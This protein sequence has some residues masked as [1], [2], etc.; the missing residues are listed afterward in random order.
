[1]ICEHLGRPAAVVASGDAAL[2]N[3]LRFIAG[4]ERITELDDALVKAA[5]LVIFVDCSDISRLGP[6]YYRLA[7]E[8]ER[9]RPTINIDH[10]VTNARFGE[11]NIVIPEA[12][13]TAEIIAGMATELG[14]EFDVKRAT[15]LLVGIYGDTL[16]LRTPS[17]TPATMRVSA[18]L[19]GA[20]A[21]L[22]AIV[23]ALFRM[24]PYST[25]ALWA[26]A[27]QRTQWRGA[28]IWT[29]VDADMLKRAGADRTEAEGLVNF[30]AGTVGARAAA[31][32]Y[33]EPSGWRVSMRSLT[34][35]VN[36]AEMLQRFNGGGHPRAAGA[37]LAPGPDARDH[38]L[39]N[40]AAQLGPRQSAQAPVGS[41]NDPI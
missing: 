23:D 1:M 19:L 41:S 11:F 12:A 37:K 33:E 3:N 28:L 21:N 15:T 36:V 2:P 34:P 29:E 40:I 39:D 24:K 26:A 30:L 16:G 20:G 22:D 4:S 7:N 32:L 8:L 35:D 25:V 10:H 9:H 18:E 31:L 27:L 5:D 17:T 6:L 14:I 38:F 13:A